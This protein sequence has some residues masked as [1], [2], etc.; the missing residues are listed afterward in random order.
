MK[1]V[2]LHASEQKRR[3]AGHVARYEENRIARITEKFESKMKRSSGR[4][5]NRWKDDH[6]SWRHIL[7]KK[8]TI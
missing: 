6:R 1:D 8:V 7:E 4:P 3:W 2:L 5:K